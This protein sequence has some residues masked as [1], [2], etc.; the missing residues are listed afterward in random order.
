MDPGGCETLYL[1]AFMW[2]LL[3]IAFQVQ[4]AAAS[5]W[6]KQLLYEAAQYDDSRL[7][8]L[9]L[10]FVTTK[11]MK[12][13]GIVCFVMFCKVLFTSGMKRN[14]ATSRHIIFIK[15]LFLSIFYYL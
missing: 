9:I 12:Q 11:Q 15:C 2:R 14:C 8:T 5:T 1:T 7:Q 3:I 13:V 6:L 4:L 10:P